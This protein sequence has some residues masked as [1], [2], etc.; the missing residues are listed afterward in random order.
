MDKNTRT[1]TGKEVVELAK[2]V[3]T[4]RGGKD[5]ASETSWT[6]A[7]S[8]YLIRETDEVVWVSAKDRETI[9]AW[10]AE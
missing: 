6:Q 1:V 10:E 9:D 4:T 3:N 7:G 8:L 2:L 5:M